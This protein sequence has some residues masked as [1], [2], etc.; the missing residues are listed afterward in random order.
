MHPYCQQ[1]PPTHP[2]VPNANACTVCVPPARP[3]MPTLTATVSKYSA[4]RKPTH[5]SEQPAMDPTHTCPD[6]FMHLDH[7]HHTHRDRQQLHPLTSPCMHS[8]CQRV[9]NAHQ[10]T[11]VYSQHHPSAHPC[12]CTASSPHPHTL[13]AP[14]SAHWM[15]THASEQPAMSRSMHASRPPGSHTHPCMHPASSTHNRTCHQI[16]CALGAHPCIR[17]ATTS[18]PHTPASLQAT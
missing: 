1:L 3:H 16:L 12:I 4:H 9:P 6:L 18:R 13:T 2:W 11:Y 10:C 17:T 14:H 15:P 8:D 5:A 7:M